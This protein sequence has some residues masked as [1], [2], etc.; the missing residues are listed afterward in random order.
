MIQHG[1]TPV[2]Y[3]AVHG[4]HEVIEILCEHG[5]NVN[6]PDVY[7]NTPGYWTAGLGRSETTKLL[8]R[9][10]ADLNKSNLKG[11]TPLILAAS[12][13]N[14]E[15][16]KLLVQLGVNP[17]HRDKQGMLAAERAFRTGHKDIFRILQRYQ[18]AYRLQVF[19]RG[20]IRHRLGTSTGLSFVRM[21][22]V[23]VLA[24][25]ANHV[26]NQNAKE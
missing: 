18:P 1:K 25:I 6:L 10:G 4:H 12:N 17:D 24:L 5:A 8:H 21:L 16:V 3:A 26:V 7:G 2:Y 23:D 19:L 14:V 9:S 11:S 13:G 15:G 22:P 20:T